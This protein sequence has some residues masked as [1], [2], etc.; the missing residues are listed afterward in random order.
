MESRTGPS[1]TP[2]AQSAQQSMMTMENV[3]IRERE[4]QELQ[5]LERYVRRT[6]HNVQRQT[7]AVLRESRGNFI[8]FG[9]RGVR[10]VLNIIGASHVIILYYY[11]V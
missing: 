2:T 10:K 3:E 11:Y 8:Q 5:D 1:P 6:V 7:R 4:A 9:A